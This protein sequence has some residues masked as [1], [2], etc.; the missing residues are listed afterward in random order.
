M[1]IDNGIRF[2]NRSCD[3]SDVEHVFE[4]VCRELAINHR[5]TQ[6]SHPWTNGQTRQIN[7]TI[8]GACVKYFP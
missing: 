3:R 5:L 4:R 2:A 6:V 8:K 1:L 7:L